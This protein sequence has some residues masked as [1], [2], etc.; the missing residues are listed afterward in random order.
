M[1]TG[2]QNDFEQATDIARKMVTQWGMSDLG[3]LSFGRREEQVFLGKEIAHHQDYSDKTAIEIDEAVHSIVMDCYNRA[4]HLIETN[5]DGLKQLADELL[6]RETLIT[7]DI[8][9]ILGPRPQ[10]SPIAS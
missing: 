3:P 10:T 1:T 9:E 6:K 2:A 8:E 7:A 4:R 5:I